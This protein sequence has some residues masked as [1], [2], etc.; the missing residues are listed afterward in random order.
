MAKGVFVLLNSGAGALQ[1]G[2]DAALGKIE[3][4]LAQAGYEVEIAAA[5]GGELQR[6]LDDRLL[7]TPPD[8]VIVGGGDGTVSSTAATLCES[9][10]ALGVLPLGTMNLFARSLGMPMELDAALTALATAKRRKIDLGEV[11]GRLFT[12]HVSM[13]LH[14]RLVAMREQS[15]YGSRAGKMLATLRALLAV[16]QRPPRLVLRATVDGTVLDIKTPALVVSNNVFGSDHLPYADALDQGVLG[17]YILTSRR[18]ADVAQVT[19]EAL[20]GTWQADGRL[21][22][23][24]AKSVT[25]EGR[26]RSARISASVDGELETFRGPI[27]LAIRPACL[28][29]LV[30]ETPA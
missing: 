16:M 18:P 7:R 30:P 12:H 9:G 21:R 2:F 26:G 5:A 20:L 11:N 28:E 4:A 13:G 8:A 1:G 27:E 19:L 17:I 3:E 10:I 22:T 6:C 23:L 14:S 15:S 25:V 29:V 24:T